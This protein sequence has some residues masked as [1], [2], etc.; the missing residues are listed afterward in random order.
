MLTTL[1]GILIEV[2][3]DTANAYISI[4]ITPLGIVTDFRSRHMLNARDPMLVTA[5]STSLY[6]TLAGMVTEP[7][8][9]GVPD[10]SS[11]PPHVTVA[12]R[13]LPSRM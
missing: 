13:L 5:Y 12:V 9:S 8:Y 1:A 2:R 3:P 11:L 10:D 4:F 6:V 7:V